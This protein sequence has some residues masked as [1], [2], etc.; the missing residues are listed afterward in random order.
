MTS[1]GSRKSQPEHSHILI[2]GGGEEE[3]R[4]MQQAGGSRGRNGSI[5]A[6]APSP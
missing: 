4:R 2:L 3:Q 6:F 5:K 1:R